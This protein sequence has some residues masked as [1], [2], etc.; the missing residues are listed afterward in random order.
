VGFR[1]FAIWRFRDLAISRFGNLVIRRFCD[2]AIPRP[3]DLAVRA[4]RSIKRSKSRIREFAKSK[5]REKMRQVNLGHTGVQV[6]ALGFGGMPLS[7][8]GRPPEAQARQTLHAA[9]DAGITLIDTADVY[10]RDDDDIGHN[11]RLIAAVLTERPGSEQVR[12]A[13]KGGMRRPNGEW[14]RDG[15]PQHLRE[16]CEASLRALNT[17][18]IFL[19]QLHAP[20]PK[21]PFEKSIETLARLKEEGKIEHVGL[22]NV[23]VDQ[24]RAARRIVDVQSVQNRLSPFFREPLENGVVAECD[25]EGLTFLAYS[26]LGGRRLAQKVPNYVVLKKLGEKFGA[27]P[28]AIVL[29]WVRA[30]GSSVLPIPGASKPENARSSAASAEIDLTPEE[31]AAIAAIRFQP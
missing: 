22:S 14:T 19:Y 8:Q 6:S 2:S 17:K 30:T 20:D 26:P 7:I 21:V 15:S 23:S 9:L 10:C 25:R 24:I 3:G 5:S 12:V 29:A 16:A 27:S 13:T 31:G 1:D 28:H 4:R 18:Q 11:E